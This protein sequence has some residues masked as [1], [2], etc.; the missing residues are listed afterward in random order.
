MS[1][2]LMKH[3][4]SEGLA[5]TLS[6]RLFEVKPIPCGKQLGQMDV[7]GSLCGISRRTALIPLFRHPNTPR[8]GLNSTQSSKI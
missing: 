3:Q 7:L 2:G 6:R 4:L 5:K 8:G 1:I